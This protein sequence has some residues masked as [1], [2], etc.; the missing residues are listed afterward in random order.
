MQQSIAGST[1]PMSMLRTTGPAQQAQPQIQSFASNFSHLPRGPATLTVPKSTTVLRQVNSPALQ[2]PAGVSPSLSL[3][4]ARAP[5]HQNKTTATQ[6][7]RSQSP[8]VGGQ[9]VLPA[10]PQDLSRANLSIHGSITPVTPGPYPMHITLNRMNTPLNSD[11][12]GQARTIAAQVLQNDS[13]S[14]LQQRINVSLSD[15]NM[16]HRITPDHN[17]PG[18]SFVSQA[19]NNSALG[20]QG[21]VISTQ[22]QVQQGPSIK[23]VNLA[24]S[25]PVMINSMNPSQANTTTTIASSTAPIPI[26]KVTPQRLH[27]V[28]G[29][30]A[31]I[32]VPHT[33]SSASVLSSIS[34]SHT[35]AVTSLSSS[36]P[37]SAIHS[38][39]L[40]PAH[41]DQQSHSNT[42]AIIVTPEYQTRPPGSIISLPSSIGTAMSSAIVSQAENRSSSH[43]Q[44]QLNI[45]HTDPV[46]YQQM[47]QPVVRPG[48][49]FFIQNQGKIQT[50]SANLAASQLAAISVASSNVRFNTGAMVMVD[51]LRYQQHSLHSPFNTGTTT[52]NAMAEKTG[53]LS[54]ATVSSSIYTA[55]VGVQSQLQGGGGGTVSV[56]SGLSAV[57]VT[58]PS[59]SPRPSIL[60]KRTSEAAGVVIRKPNFN[61][62]QD[63]RCHSPPR[64]DTNNSGLSSPKISTKN[65]SPLSENSQSSTDTALSSN[66]ATTPTHNHNN[67]GKGEGEDCIENGPSTSTSMLNNIPASPA[68]S[69]TGSLSEASPRKRA[70]KQLLHANEELK[71]NNSSSDEELENNPHQHREEAVKEQRAKEKEIRGEY[72]DEEGVRWVLNKPKPTY[73]L[74]QPE[75]INNKTKNNHF[76]R[77]SD[78]KPK[79]ERRPTVHELSNQRGITQKVNGW[80]LYFTASQLEEL[81]DVERDMQE[82]F[83]EVQ[84]ALAQIPTHKMNS[85]EAIKIHE[86]SQANIQRCELIQNQLT[87]AR[88]SMIRTLE[89]KPRIQEI[90]SKHV[91]KRPI[92][93]KERT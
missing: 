31:Q 48:T 20:P 26:A 15:S 87:D 42:G 6:A 12:T 51:Q 73:V 64:V 44:Q 23:S 62:N 16:H 74:L 59:S 60:R 14:N 90:V 78:V 32:P 38:G 82:Q 93:K 4:L 89:H 11:A 55:S 80:K 85:E 39:D 77:Y 17:R 70:R 37:S 54:R 84:A 1:I 40:D 58:N 92:K 43:T 41:H 50:Q 67:K 9:P 27:T 3:P 22:N 86:M 76:I 8:A 30:M 72:T 53:S 75:F 13:P 24:V 35:N 52:S 18:I 45:R 46:W 91:S 10:Q 57:P 83:S 61:L 71:D 65:F 66:D 5:L 69:H 2:I 19:K 21:K 49:N 56:S 63:S 7:P 25:T 29:N 34:A 68:V 47:L 81:M 88:A 36:L 28:S 79:E 33:P